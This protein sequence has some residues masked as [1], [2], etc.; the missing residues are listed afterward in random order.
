MHLIRKW[1]AKKGNHDRE[2]SHDVA[3]AQIAI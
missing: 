3:A 1:M 2:T